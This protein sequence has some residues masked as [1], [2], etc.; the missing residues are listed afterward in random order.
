MS[1]I[2]PYQMDFAVSR[3]VNLYRALELE[4]FKQ[5]AKQ[6]KTSGEPNISDWRLDKMNQLQMLNKQTIKELAKVSGLAAEDI[7]SKIHD[8]GYQTI[9]DIDKELKGHYEIKPL[10]TNIDSIMESITKQTFLELDNFVNQTLVSTQYGQGY[11]SKMYENIINEVAGKFI[12][13]TITLDK[14]IEQ[15]VMQWAK[16]G[17][18]SNFIDKGGHTWSLERYVDTVMRSTLNRTYNELRTSRMAEYGINTVIMSTVY[19]SAARCAFCQ[20]KVLDMRPISQNDSEYPS[21][22]EFGYGKPGGTLGIN[23][24]HSIFPFIPG[25]STNN[26]PQINPKQAIERSI[27]RTKQRDIERKIVKTK[28][29]IAI[30]EALNSDNLPKYKELLKKQQ[31]Q[32]RELLGDADWLSRNYKREKMYTP[33]EILTKGKS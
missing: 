8:A 11:V 21:I 20:G 13:G 18:E 7:E 6:L 9:G 16:K 30:L 19:D 33:T 22:Y 24:R 12:T 31:G 17:V 5:I 14:A 29:N 25:V 10:P 27:V 28:K 3:T 15:S 32:M 23:C 4:I 26:Q 2:T 1:R